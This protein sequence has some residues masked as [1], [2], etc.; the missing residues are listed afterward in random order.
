M[1]MKTNP[2]V[3]MGLLVQGRRATSRL[4]LR[5][6]GGGAGGAL[7][8]LRVCASFRGIAI[9]ALEALPRRG[10]RLCVCPGGSGP[11]HSVALGPSPE[12]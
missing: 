3:R 2:N 11:V 1:E 6:G 8:A 9:T 7:G 5:L 10:L 12:R 4:R